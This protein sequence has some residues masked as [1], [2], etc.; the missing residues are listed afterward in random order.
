MK[1]KPIFRIIGAAGILIFCCIGITLHEASAA[2]RVWRR[3]DGQPVLKSQQNVWPVA[4]MIDNLPAARPQAGLD[5]ASV[6]YEALAEGGIPR[7]MAVFARYDVGL[8]GPV[9]STRPYFVRYAAEYR[10]GLAHAG[11]SPDALIF[12]NS[13]RIPN[14]EGLQGK[15]A[16][17]FFRVGY[18]VHSLFTNGQRLSTALKTLHYDKKKPTY[19]P[20]MYVEQPPFAKRRAGKH[21][22]SVDLGAG[23][24]YQIRYDY[25]RK[26]NV[27]SRST[28]GIPH[29]DRLT[30]QQLVAKNVIF[31]L[32]PK[33]RVLDRKGRLDLKVLGKGRAILLQNGFASTI[34]WEK[35]APYSRTVFRTSSG[36]PVQLVRG[37]TWITVIPAGKKYQLF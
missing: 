24:S 21:G 34:R 1:Q 11:G 32:V 2:T 35:S 26:R 3:I 17:T 19:Q 15:T 29:R 6:V 37:S 10:A 30:R 9:R 28:G 5:K 4:V 31:I 16:S 33:E 20:W 7:F 27:Y 25:D 8:I 36:R 14:I 18:G 12:L 22:A 23:R 13:L